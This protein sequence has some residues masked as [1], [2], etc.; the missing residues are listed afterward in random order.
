MTTSPYLE[1][2]AV[3]AADTPFVAIAIGRSFARRE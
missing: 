3:Q 2:F 1:R